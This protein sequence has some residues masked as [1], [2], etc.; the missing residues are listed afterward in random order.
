MGHPSIPCRHPQCDTP[1]T[2]HRQ[3]PCRGQLEQ[4]GAA[5]TGPYQQEALVQETSLTGSHR[6]PVHQFQGRAMQPCRMAFYSLA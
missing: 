2:G 3:Q 4:H 5:P 1:P 6:A